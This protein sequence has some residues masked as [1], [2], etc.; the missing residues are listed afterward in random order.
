[1]R[2]FLTIACIGA[3]PK[4]I[5]KHE[6]VIYSLDVIIIAIIHLPKENKDC[7]AI[8]MKEILH[9]RSYGQLKTN[10]HSQ[11]ERAHLPFGTITPTGASRENL[12]QDICRTSIYVGLLLLACGGPGPLTSVLRD[13]RHSVGVG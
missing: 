8:Q 13:I 7:H 5:S 4:V 3:Y 9:M 6:E 11:L 1:M 2:R 10:I 12:P